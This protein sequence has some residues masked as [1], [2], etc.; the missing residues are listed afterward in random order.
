MTRAGSLRP[1]LITLSCAIL[2]AISA[3]GCTQLANP[4]APQSTV[5]PGS[6]WGRMIQDLYGLIFWMAVVVFV[7]VEGFLLY[8]V[9]RFRRR[10]EGEAVSQTHGNTLL[11]VAWTVVPSIVLLMIAVPTISTIFIGDMPPPVTT[12]PVRVTVIGHQWWWEFRY[13]DLGV[14]TANELHLPAGRTA[15]IEVT[16]ADVIH[17]FW[18]PKMGGKVDAIPTRINTMWFTPDAAAVGEHFGQCAEFCGLQHA[19]MR[20]RLFVDTAAN[21]DAWVQQQRAPA[22]AAAAGDAQQ[23]AELFQRSACITCHTIKGTNAQGTIGPDLTHVGSRTTI[24]AGMIDN[25]PENL[26]HW[27]RDPQGVKV[28]N[29]MVLP[30][31]SESDARLFAAY[32]QSLR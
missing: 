13:P 4:S 20:M 32:L 2:F 11:E 22:S 25:T 9:I 21:F 16:S 12:N 7:G 8:T 29:K 26:A 27:I 15:T 3:G 14:V 1:R 19:N 28:G 17:S 23:G 24:A 6:D 31:V 10:R 30:Q 18:V 5:F